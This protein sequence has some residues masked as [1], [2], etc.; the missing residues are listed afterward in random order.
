MAT[1]A[2]TGREAWWERFRR[3]SLTAR[4]C[5]TCWAQRMIL[6]PGPLGLVPVV[7]EGCDG[8]GKVRA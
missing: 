6:E 1:I 4:D 3:R 8:T 7:C 2:P 5:P